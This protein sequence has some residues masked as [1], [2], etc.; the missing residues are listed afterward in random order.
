M[1]SP[2]SQED[3]ANGGEIDI[4]KVE[5][6][7]IAFPEWGAPSDKPTGAPRNPS[8]PGE[9]VGFAVLALGR[10]SLEEILPAF[11]Q[12]RQAR[13]T[14]LIS[15]TP[16]KLEAVGDQ[17]G[18]GPER[19]FGYAEVDR[20]RAD[21]SVEVI[22]VVSPNA[23]HEAH[24]R[25]AADAGKHVLCEKPMTTDPRS[26]KR[27]I[28]SCRQAGRLLMIA[29]RS[30]YEPHMREAI[31]IARSGAIGR[32]K[33]I[34]ALNIE[35]LGDPGQW[36]LRGELAGGGALPDVGLYCLNIARAI[37][38]EE[39]VE[40]YGAISTPEGD[41]R[42]A[43]VEDQVSF[44]LRFPSGALANCATGYDGHKQARLMINGQ[45]GWIDMDHAFEYRGQRLRLA[46]RQGEQ[47]QVCELFPKPDNQFAL[48]I[49][50]M[51][52]CVR[53]SRVPRTPGEE[54]LQ[55]QRLMEAIY[56]SAREGRPLRLP[57]FKGLDVTRG[58]A[59]DE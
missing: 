33:L 57:A 44:F 14:A 28:S 22:Y 8:P 26:A 58:P 27:M 7:R 47:E 20:L 23:C 48:E 59:L 42:F 41:P 52:G 53:S 15:G 19:R 29:Y 50:H 32:V 49:D 25:F 46:R 5:A 16:D 6:G 34:D 37:T 10:L 2:G 35:N 56:T 30:Q 40:V 17:Y 51:A 9:R 1:S 11:G 13:L 36:R 31:R 12:T 45:T 3:G 55:D 18:I 39:P 43:S 24:V 38:G 54:G 4:G 21:A